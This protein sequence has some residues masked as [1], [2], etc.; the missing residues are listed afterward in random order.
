M[1]TD[2]RTLLSVAL[3][4][5]PCCTCTESSFHVTPMHTNTH[6]TSRSHSHAARPLSAWVSCCP[7]L[8]SRITDSRTELCLAAPACAVWLPMSAASR[9]CPCCGVLLHL[10]LQSL[11]SDPCLPRLLPA[12]EIL[13]MEQYMSAH[14][15]CIAVKS[16]VL[17]AAVL[18]MRVQAWPCKCTFCVCKWLAAAALAQWHCDPLGL[19]RWR[20]LCLLVRACAGCLCCGPAV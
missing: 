1:S 10:H 13:R 18:V 14:H 19:P 8:M 17:A 6:A 20:L 4:G 3:S 9:D 11:W 15:Q 5:A 7:P 12:R 2:R 16:N